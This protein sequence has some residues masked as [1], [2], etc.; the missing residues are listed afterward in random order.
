[1]FSR[2]VEALGNCEA[3]FAAVCKTGDGVLYKM[4]A[5]VMHEAA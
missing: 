4:S 1:M 2:F 3:A 5:K